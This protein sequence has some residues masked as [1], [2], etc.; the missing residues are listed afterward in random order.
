MSSLNKSLLPV[1]TLILEGVL[2]RV[3]RVTGVP[4]F[5]DESA[6]GVQ[7]MKRTGTPLR[8]PYI[9]LNHAATS[10][11]DRSVSS[12]PASHRGRPV[13][14]SDD[15]KRAFKVMFLP[16][17]LH[18]DFIY[19]GDSSTHRRHIAHGLLLAR[20][21]GWLKFSVPYGASSFE[22]NPEIP[23]SIDL[24]PGTSD[25]DG[26]K[27]FKLEFRLD[28]R[29]FVSYPELLEGQVIDTLLFQSFVGGGEI[30]NS[31]LEWQTE[32]RT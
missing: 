21:N 30:S 11:G 28:V 9:S 4:A 12:H 22:I 13:L 26:P 2:Q 20:R 18:V 17:N 8:Y 5:W 32:V 31:E 25:Q 24:P 19:F 6:D 16:A 10:E 15:G 23:T 14:V 29:G 1:E 7:V 3:Q 27:I